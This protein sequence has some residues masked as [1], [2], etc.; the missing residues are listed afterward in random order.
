MVT[1]TRSRKEMAMVKK[2]RKLI[3]KRKRKKTKPDRKEECTRRF[4]V[5]ADI[6]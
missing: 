6:T 5:R 2:L 3:P 4:S 1:K